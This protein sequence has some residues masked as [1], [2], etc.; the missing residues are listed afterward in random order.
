MIVIFTVQV[1]DLWDQVADGTTGVLDTKLL[2]NMFSFNEMELEWLRKVYT[3]ISLALSLFLILNEISRKTKA[4]LYRWTLRIVYTAWASVWGCRLRRITPL[5]ALKKTLIRLWVAYSLW[6][7]V[8][9]HCFSNSACYSSC[10]DNEDKHGIDIFKTIL[11]I[12]SKGLPIRI[13]FRKK[14]T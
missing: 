12:L 2:K 3:Q 4:M 7:G 5:T 8:T 14:I 13:M 1:V 11:N 10:I 6:Q 9:L